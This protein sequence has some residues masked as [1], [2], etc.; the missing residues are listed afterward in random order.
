MTN[1]EKL[2]VKEL[3]S[4][5]EQAI[6]SN[7]DVLFERAQKIHMRNGNPY[8]NPFYEYVRGKREALRGILD[9]IEELEKCFTYHNTDPTEPK[10]DPDNA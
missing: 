6:K 7:Q 4:E 8:E 10:G 1:Q 2:F 3:K 9:F 5:I